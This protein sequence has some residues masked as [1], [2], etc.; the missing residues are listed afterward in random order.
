MKLSL[1][2][3]SYLVTAIA[4]VLASFSLAEIY[5]FNSDDEYRYYQIGIFLMSPITVIVSFI[6][7]YFLI[8]KITIKP[9]IFGTLI[10]LWLIEVIRKVIYSYNSYHYR[11]DEDY[12]PNIFI[13]NTAEYYILLL[14]SLLVFLSHFLLKKYNNWL[15]ISGFTLGAIISFFTTY[16]IVLFMRHVNN[17]L[18]SYFY[19]NDN[20][21]MI[22]LVGTA[23]FT[24]LGNIIGLKKFNQI[25]EN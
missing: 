22:V 8:K 13:S 6:I 9:I 19:F 12:I 25:Q 21:L 5:H 16:A 11:S 20:E 10:G 1:N 7:C 24:I 17:S 15:H 3:T 2:V 4:A 18:M 14:P 23:I